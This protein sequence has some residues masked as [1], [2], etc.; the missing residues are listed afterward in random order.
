MKNY[1][2]FIEEVNNTSFDYDK[3][4]GIQCVDL[5]KKYLKECF[6]IK[7]P[8]NS[9]NAVTYWEDD[10]KFLKDFIKIENTPDFIPE[11]GDIMV[12]NKNRGK[13]AGHV[14][15]CTGEGDKKE[16][17]SYDLNWNGKKKV[18]KV[19]HDYKNVLGVLRYNKKE[20]IKPSKELEAGQLAK[21]EVKFTGSLNAENNALVELNGNQFWISLD[22]FYRKNDKFYIVGIIAYINPTFSILAF[23]FNDKGLKREFQINIETNK[24][25]EIN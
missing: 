20:E 2:E 13:G 22:R 23:H 25:L 17:Y 3:V 18:Q 1:D 12:W 4:S 21:V 10:K 19:K 5:I 14:S 8:L 9:G 16:F 6:N 15:I 11:K 7:V 24:L